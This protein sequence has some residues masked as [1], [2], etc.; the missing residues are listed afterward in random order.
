MTTEELALEVE[1]LRGV[2][3]RIESLVWYEPQDD[4]DTVESVR[5][6]VRERDEARAEVERLKDRCASYSEDGTSWTKTRNADG[7][8]WKTITSGAG[9]LVAVASSSGGDNVIT[10]INGTEWIRRSGIPDYA[11]NGS[12][13]GN[14]LFVAVGDSGKIMTSANVSPTIYASGLFSDPFEPDTPWIVLVGYDTVGFYAFGKASKT[15]SLNGYQVTTQSTIVQANNYL[16]L[17]RGDEETPLRWNGQWDSQFELVPDTTLPTTYGSI[18]KSSQATYYQNRLWVQSGK[19]EDSAIVKVID[20]R[21][22]AEGYNPATEEYWVELDNRV[23]RRLPHRYG[24]DAV[25]KPK[26][27]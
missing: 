24:E 25:E 26:I 11:W 20:Q 4:D 23:A 22:A 18:P 2:L 6:M 19:D 13:F 17:F 12:G 21:L 10:S 3:A 8:T 9:V 7:D 1:R 16:Y 14:G 5:A 27:S 15:V